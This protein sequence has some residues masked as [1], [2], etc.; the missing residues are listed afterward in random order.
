MNYFF[1][2]N[3]FNLQTSDFDIE[4]IPRFT[5]K[6]HELFIT[7]LE[8]S[9]DKDE[10]NEIEKKNLKI[11]LVSLNKT[12]LNLSKKT[13]YCYVFIEK[14]EKVEVYFK[15]F[16]YIIIEN[17]KLIYKFSKEIRNSRKLGNFYARINLTGMLKFKVSYTKEIYKIIAKNNKKKDVLEYSL[18]E[19]KKILKIEGDLYKRYYNFENKVLNPIKKDIEIADVLLWFEKVK[20]NQS[21]NSKVIGIKIHYVNGPITKLHKETNEIMKKYHDDIEDYARTY[22]LIYQFKKHSSMEDTL[23]YIEDN[24]EYIFK[25]E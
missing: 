4:C 12:I 6:E 19:F 16:D 20:N 14:K 7:L 9:D 24:Y 18:D 25:E 3:D 23:K 10:H 22:E 8:N 1:R 13:I 15:L 5:K 2:T 11:D 21:K 17:T